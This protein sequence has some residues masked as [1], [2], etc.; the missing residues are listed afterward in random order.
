MHYRHVCLESIGYELPSQILTSDEIER[1]LQPLYQRLRLPEGRLELMTGIRER[2]LW[3]PGMLP[4][5]KSIASAQSAIQAADIDRNRIGALIHGS[6]CRDDLEPATACSVHRQLSL[7]QECMIYDTSNACLGILNGVLQAANMIELGQIEAAIVV[8]TESSRQLTDTTIDWLNGNASISR[9]EMKLAVASLT[10]GSGS[11]AILLVHRD[12][13]RTNNQIVAASA[14]ANT[15]FNHLCRSDGD[16]AA[17]ARMQ[18]L[19]QTD[20]KQLMQEGIATGVETFEGFLAECGWSRQDLHKTFCHQVGVAHRKLM[21]EALRLQ[22]QFDFATYQWLG[23]TGSVAL[24]IAMAIGLTEGHVTPGENIGLLGIGSG[25][26]CVMVGVNWQ[27]TRVLGSTE[28]QQS[29]SN[30]IPPYHAHFDDAAKRSA[31]PGPHI[32][33]DSPSTS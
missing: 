11:C 3:P 33:G 4:S 32:R 15:H 7:P 17:G 12:I 13:S 25:I 1:R 2:R 29:Q 28:P 10:I 26:N 31:A 20:S 18:P 5:E 14:R 6:V 27:E 30:A 19:M 21:I 24:P 8:G 16:Q 22:L 9:D 23:N